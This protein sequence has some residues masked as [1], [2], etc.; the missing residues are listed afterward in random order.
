MGNKLNLEVGSIFHIEA[1]GFRWPL[2]A[3]VMK[4]KGDSLEV[5]VSPPAG[6]ET[7]DVCG[8]SRSLSLNGATG[9]VTCMAPGC[10]KDF[11]YDSEGFMENLK[12]SDLSPV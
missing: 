11:G 3:E 9:V 2:K 7:C 8:H 1:E 5:M 4:R 10:G 6:P 12:V